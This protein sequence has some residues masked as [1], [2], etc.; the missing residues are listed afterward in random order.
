MIRTRAANFVFLPLL[1][2]LAVGTSDLSAGSLPDFTGLV[3]RNK[4]AV[5]NISSKQK[6]QVHQF[7]KGME[8]PDLPEDSPFNELFRYFFGDQGKLPE[9]LDSRS[10]GSGFVISADGYI[11]T[12]YHV[13][14]GADEIIVRTSERHEFIADVVGGDKRSDI[15]L[16]KIDAKDLPVAT[17]GESESLKVGE[18]VLAIGSPFGFDHSVTAGIVSATGRNLPSENYVPF[19]QTDVAINPGNSGGPLFNLDGEVVGVN[20]Q[21]Y[22]R[23]G[24]FMGLSF[25]IPIEVAMNVAQQLKTQGHVTRGWLGVIIQDVTR[26][27]AESFRMKRPRGA[28][29]AKVLPKSPAEQADLEVGDVI[30]SYNGQELAN[31]AA[32]PPLVGASPVDKPARMGVIRDGKRIEVEVKIGELPS[33]EELQVSSRW[34]ARSAPNRLG[35][36]V[37]PLTEEQR[38]QLGIEK[39]V[40]VL[41]DEVGAGPARDAG[42]VEGDVIL[43]LGNRWVEDVEG[44]REMADEL[45]DGRSVAI[46]VQRENGPLFLAL[47]VPKK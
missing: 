19:I 10:L 36:R 47:R 39:P 15:A 37:S 2:L 3:E 1:A 17:I 40:G 31:S 41:V 8:I 27:L 29:I 28:L 18:W 4:A 33:E 20:S 12:N 43:Q 21:I 32:L 23:T 22:S 16:I 44:F 34:P 35:L 6:R 24:G 38:E 9:E 25:A 7:P 13:V 26:E 45:P 5:V 46:L 42:I 30:L 14:E 11:L